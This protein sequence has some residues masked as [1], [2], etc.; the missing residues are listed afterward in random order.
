MSKPT[1]LISGAGIAGPIC[2]YWLSKAGIQ[3]TVIERASSLRKDG[4][5]IDIRGAAKQVVRMMGVEETIMAFVTHEKGL[6]FVDSSGRHRAVFPSDPENAMS[7]TSDIEIMR[8]RLAM[9]FYEVSKDVT[10]YIFGDYITDIQDIPASKVSVTFSKGQKRD[11]DFVVGADGMRSKMRNLVMPP[12][13]KKEAEEQ[14]YSLGEY[15]AFF[16]I[17]SLPNDGEWALWYNAPRRRSI[18]RR[19]DTD[20]CARA[21]LSVISSQLKGHEQTSI[22]SQKA[23]LKSIFSDA[24]WEAARVMQGL[25]TC[26]DF[27][28]QEIAQVKI[29]HWYKG[30]VGL[31]GDAAYCPSPISGMGTSLAIL[32]AYVLAGEMMNC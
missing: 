15:M 22:P 31:I 26:E 2:A 27:Y 16:S 3:C 7:F 14:L 19:P 11:F 25:E 20:G 23:L 32:G 24:G 18:M 1:A 28:M 8:G 5:G 12:S 17:P 21:Y 29:P 4:Q 30:R 10:E 6:A 9:I 13:S